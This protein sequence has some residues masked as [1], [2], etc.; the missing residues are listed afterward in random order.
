MLSRSEV[1]PSPPRRGGGVR[2]RRR[3]QR[4]A[5]RRAPGGPRPRSRARRAARGAGPPRPRG[6]RGGTRARWR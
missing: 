3:A 1:S 2:W 5:A 6:A 4:R